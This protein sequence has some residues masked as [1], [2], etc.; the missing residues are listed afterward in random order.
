MD[1]SVE[2]TP[3]RKSSLCCHSCGYR[4][5]N[6]EPCGRCGHDRCRKCAL[7]LHGRTPGQS[8]LA[9]ESRKTTPHRQ[10]QRDTGTDG[11]PASGTAQPSEQTNDGDTFSPTYGRR[12]QNAKLE[13][14][15]IP[16]RPVSA[17]PFVLADRDIHASYSAP[18]FFLPS[19]TRVRRRRRPSECVPSR[20]RDQMTAKPIQPLHTQ[21]TEGSQDKYCHGH[22]I[23]CPAYRNG[24]LQN[25]AETGKQRF[26]DKLQRKIDQLY[27]H[28]EELHTSQHAMEHLAA[29]LKDSASDSIV[30]TGHVA[31]KIE[32]IIDVSLQELSGQ[33]TQDGT[34]DDKTIKHFDSE[35]VEYR[36]SIRSETNSVRSPKPYSYEADDV[37]GIDPETLE[38]QPS[39]VSNGGTKLRDDSRSTS[40]NGKEAEDGDVIGQY[41]KIFSRDTIRKSGGESPQ[42]GQLATPLAPETPSLTGY[43]RHRQDTI[44]CARPVD[45]NGGQVKWPWLRRVETSDSATP[46]NTTRRGL[47]S[48]ASGEKEF[49]QKN[50]G[51]QGIDNVSPS[52]W[53]S[54]L[55]RTGKK[56]QSP[57]TRSAEQPSVP[58]WRLGLVRKLRARDSPAK[59]G[60]CESCDRAR[61]KFSADKCSHQSSPP[62]EASIHTASAGD[63]AGGPRLSLR[64]VEQ[65]LERKRAQ[66]DFDNR[67]STPRVGG[68]PSRQ[69]HPPSM[70]CDE[71]ETGSC[72]TSHSCAW[73]EGYDNL[74]N[75]IENCEAM[76]NSLET[77]PEAETLDSGRTVGTAAG[78]EPQDD[79]GIEGITVVVHMKD[80][81]DVV[82]STDVT[83]KKSKSEEESPISSTQQT[84]TR[85]ERRG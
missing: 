1:R 14:P 4:V 41:R 66:G 51:P 29:E 58:Q 23:C 6:D 15:K 54:H 26:N 36:F 77:P 55:R 40:S 63:G 19:P 3:S 74:R 34:D 12:I 7:D 62:A 56:V 20:L 10:R 50:A 79:P 60:P 18:Q 65:S 46:Q 33:S 75:E 73:R 76:L 9:K 57:A 47:C 61:G 17:N 68:S 59:C 70:K 52:E 2:K 42:T 30:K 31:P 85:G 82:I 5:L 32:K 44:L 64:D 22:S 72:V 45:A 13:T 8:K 71:G 27:R 84:L 16:A 53:R 67:S 43:K 48:H 37:F 38:N 39:R 83:G 78:S 25:D 49:G 35:A 80:R 28:A 81:D 11:T 24:V 69:S 21:R